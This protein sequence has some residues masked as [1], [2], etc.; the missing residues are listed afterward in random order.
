MTRES[1]LETAAF[2][3]KQK[4]S[5]QS[6]ERQQE[7]SKRSWQAG[8]CFCKCQ[9][10]LSINIKLTGAQRTE[11]WAAGLQGGRNAIRKVPESLP[12]EP[13]LYSCGLEKHQR[14]LCGKWYH[15]NALSRAR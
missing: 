5:R 13:D 7:Q 3:D 8:S 12:K 9:S 4:F 11:D 15:Q 10:L 1:F 6:K 2:V 14:L